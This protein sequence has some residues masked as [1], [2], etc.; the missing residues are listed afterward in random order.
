MSR[1]II[2]VNQNSGYLT[3]DVA[4]AF[5]EEYDE[6][7]VMYGLNRV[8]ERNFH[9]DIVIQKTITYDRSSNIKR[10]WTWGICTIHLFFLLLFKYRGYH[11]L[12][13]TNPP[14]SYFN[15]LF[16]S[17]PFSIVVF[18][19]Y[20]DALRLI[21]IKESSFVY[22]IWKNVNKKVFNKA[23]HIITLSDGMKKQLSNYVAYEKVK[24]VSVWS[25][26]DKFKPIEKKSNP[27]LKKYNWV[28]K[29]IVLYSGN[30]GIGHKIEVLIDVAKQLEE[31]NEIIFLF[32]GEGAKKKTLIDLANKNK[33]SNVHFLT[34]QNAET[35]PYSLAAGDLAVVAL[36]PEATHAS[37]PSKTFNY[38]AVGAPLLAIGSSGSELEK[39]IIQ[40]GLGFFS[41][42]KVVSEIKDFTLEMLISKDKLRQLSQNSLQASR[43]FNFELAVHYVF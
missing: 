34:W 12:Y 22:Q 23:I 10:L 20:P 29:F 13:Y 17:N 4:N 2:I 24:V 7:V 8:T 5:K 21:G 9:P 42:G 37:V 14:M 39:L 16:F 32:V 33:L 31:I 41:E 1:K 3:I 19:T 38:M 35:L 27:F 18:D 26:S 36:E 28:N 11:V 15:A 25:A 43:K 40:Y 6:V 30:I